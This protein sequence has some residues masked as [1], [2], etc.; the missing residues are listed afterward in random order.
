VGERAALIFGEYKYKD[1][2]DEELAKLDEL[3]GNV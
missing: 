1:F 3:K 2:T